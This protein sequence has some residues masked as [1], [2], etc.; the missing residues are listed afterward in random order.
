MAG[1][2]CHKLYAYPA[3][4]RYVVVPLKGVPQ[5]PRDAHRL[6]SAGLD[7][8]LTPEHIAACDQAIAEAKAELERRKAAKLMGVNLDE[9]F[10][11]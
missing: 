7:D 10:A 8:L 11:A 9:Y 5:I 2:N 4:N 3:G 1:H 6:M